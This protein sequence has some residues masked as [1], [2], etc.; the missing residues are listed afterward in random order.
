MKDY[1]FNRHFYAGQFEDIGSI[2]WI[3]PLLI[4][5]FTYFRRRSRVQNAVVSFAAGSFLLEYIST[6]RDL[7]EAIS[8]HNNSPIYHI[9]VPILFWLMSRIYLKV[10]NQWLP[11][12]LYLAIIAGFALFSVA[13]AIWGDGFTRFPSLTIGAYSL[14]G[15]LFPITYMLRLLQSLEVPRLDQDP[16]FIAATG[17]LIYFSGNF[18]LW[19]FF[20]YINFD[21]DFFHS[22]YRVNTVLAVLLNLFLTGA[23]LL[24][25]KTQSIPAGVNQS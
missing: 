11:R 24:S 17:M 8:N 18:L 12:W 3:L 5:L 14:F 13:N 7:T 20:S 2:I 19:L 10:F 23:I 22:I 25:P 4:A 9:G 6:N 21:Y 15:M 16:L 1:I